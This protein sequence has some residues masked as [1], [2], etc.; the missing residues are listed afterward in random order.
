MGG[1]D[2][3]VRLQ[4]QGVHGDPTAGSQSSKWVILNH[5]SFRTSCFQLVSVNIWRGFQL[6][7]K[8][9]CQDSLPRPTTISPSLWLPVLNSL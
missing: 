5:S 8:A 2:V 3:G 7:N 4:S 6:V 9:E 1:G